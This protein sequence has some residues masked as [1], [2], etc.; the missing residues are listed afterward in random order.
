MMAQDFWQQVFV[1]H[2]VPAGR[3]CSPVPASSSTASGASTVMGYLGG[4][5]GGCGPLRT[6]SAQNLMDHAAMHIREADIPA[7]EAV[8]ESLVIETE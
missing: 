3:S 1:D 2:H 5:M 4:M 8:G 7:A 6:G